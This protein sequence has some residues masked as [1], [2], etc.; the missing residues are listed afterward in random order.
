MTKPA[1]VLLAGLLNDEALWQHQIEHLQDQADVIVGDTRSDDDIHTMARRVLDNAPE[2]FALAGLSMGG[3]CALEILSF[4]PERLTRL[5]L[6]DTTARADDADRMAW[7]RNFLASADGGDFSAIKRQ[8]LE[9][10]I[11]PSRHDDAGLMA[12]FDAMAERVGLETYIRQQK[13]IMSRS[14]RRHL[15]AEVTIPTTVICGR[16]DRATPLPW[17]EEIAEAIPDARLHVIE[18]AGHLTPMERPEQVTG[19]LRD[20]LGS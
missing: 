3:Y 10:Y 14:D 4:A 15:L 13:A 5:A 2:R 20:W 7:R 18:T 11:H 9:A 16:Q 1:L 8:S 6:L 17:S 12:A 19:I